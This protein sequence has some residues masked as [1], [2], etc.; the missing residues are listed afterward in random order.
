M[1]LTRCFVFALAGLMAAT[2]CSQ[3]D[4]KMAAGQASGKP[5]VH[6]ESGLPVVPLKVQSGG[7]THTFM[8]EVARSEAEQAKGLM[9]RTQM[10]AD[11]GMIFPEQTPRRAA[12]WMRNTVIPLDIIFIGTDHRIL[13]I[14]ANAVPYDET[15]LPA[16]GVAIGVLELNGGRAAQLG[17]KP[18]DEVRW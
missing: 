10:G 8:V 12:F 4:D 2:G 16:K 18:G 14:A 6:S 3:G 7:R 15:P 5:A 9:F 13:N 1:R 17:I 11:E